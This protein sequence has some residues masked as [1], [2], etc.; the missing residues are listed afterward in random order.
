M[1]ATS[2][3]ELNNLSDEDCAS[4]LANVVEHYPAAGKYLT[5]QRP[6]QNLEELLSAINSLLDNLPTVGKKVA[7]QCQLVIFL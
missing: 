6:F 3:S 2:L 4:L 7:S 5:T 1:M